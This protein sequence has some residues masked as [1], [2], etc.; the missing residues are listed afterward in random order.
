MAM[1]KDWP[2]WIYASLCKHFDTHR[3]EI[4]LTIEGQ[5]IIDTAAQDRFELRVDGPTGNESSRNYWYLAV[6][7]N[8]LVTSVLDDT[9]LHKIYASVGIAAAAFD[10]MIPV[11][12]YGKNQDDDD[13]LLGCLQ[14][15]QNGS[16]RPV[17]IEHYGQPD[18]ATK[19]LQSSVGASYYIHLERD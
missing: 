4:P 7:V 3:G 11:Y 2:R 13:S 8:L 14:L 19:A 1:H 10:G 5:E 18:P 12:K 16:R 17:Y 9:N 15:Q 6:E